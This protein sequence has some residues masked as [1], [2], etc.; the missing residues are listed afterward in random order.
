[1][2]V[3]ERILH[4]CRQLACEKGFYSMNVDELAARAGVSKRTLYRYFRSKEEI[5]ESTIDSFMVE[6][7]QAINHLVEK[8]PNPEVLLNVLF[9][10]L[11][12]TGQF[13]INP[14]T[15]NDL[16]LHYPHLWEKIDSFR[17]ER[18]SILIQ[19]WLNQSDRDIDPRIITAA[20]MA[21]IQAVLNPGFIINNGLT[22]ESAAQ[23]LSRLLIA[24]LM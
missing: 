1:M 3:K 23:Q 9:S 19:H 5:I 7:S 16:R 8:E 15:L 6:T 24:I 22:F 12:T 2:N 13:I 20:T 18:M 21:C 17:M 10:H 11:F 14:A 4:A